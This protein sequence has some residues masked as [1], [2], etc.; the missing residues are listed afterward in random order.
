[1]STQ[2]ERRAANRAAHALKRTQLEEQWAL[3]AAEKQEDRK[4]RRAANRAAWWSR[5][6]MDAPEYVGHIEQVE[7]VEQVE[8]DPILDDDDSSYIKMPTVTEDSKVVS[9]SDT[10]AR[11]EE[12]HWFITIDGV[13]SGTVSW[14]D[15]PL[16]YE[17]P[18][19]ESY[20][21]QNEAQARGLAELYAMDYAERSSAVARFTPGMIFGDFEVT[22]VADKSVKIQRVG[23]ACSAKRYKIKHDSIHGDYVSTK[24]GKFYA[25]KAEFKAA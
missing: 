25:S 23:Y 9:A 14:S 10:R 22:T 20:P 17:T 16:V 7:Q 19:G 4:R 1:M 8:L 5:Y 24:V 3:A 13:D 18:D 12:G 11:G 6:G 2:S 15:E 21:C